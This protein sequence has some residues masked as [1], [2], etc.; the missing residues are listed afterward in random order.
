M[1][2]ILKKSCSSIE[3]MPSAESYRD[4]VIESY[5]PR[6]PTDFLNFIMYMYKVGEILTSA[7]LPEKYQPSTDILWLDL[8]QLC[9][10]PWSLFLTT[11][12]GAWTKEEEAVDILMIF[13]PDVLYRNWIIPR[14]Y[15][16]IKKAWMRSPITR[17]D[18]ME[19]RNFVN[20]LLVS[21]HKSDFTYQKCPICQEYLFSHVKLECNHLMHEECM[22]RWL[23][24]KSICPVCRKNII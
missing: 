24:V 11:K 8:N 14:L 17:F 13:G 16:T 12:V 4:R 15:E 20:K 2:I 23:N 18:E 6:N 21:I 5:S 1:D 19:W 3:I 22:K 9:N 10:T 7:K